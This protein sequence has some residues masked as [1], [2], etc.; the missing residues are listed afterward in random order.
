MLILT[1]NYVSNISESCRV[2]Y[3]LCTAESNKMKTAK[4]DPLSGGKKKLDLSNLRWRQEEVKWS[5]NYA[6]KRFRCFTGGQKKKMDGGKRVKTKLIPNVYTV[7]ISSLNITT[8]K[9]EFDTKNCLSCAQTHC[10]CG[11]SEKGLCVWQVQEMTLFYIV[12]VKC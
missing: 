11:P 1:Q 7:R 9:N 6:I 3:V 12:A 10:L 4:E 2:F 8:A 5:A